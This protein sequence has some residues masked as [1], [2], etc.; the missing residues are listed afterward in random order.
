MSTEEVITL[1]GGLP[2]WPP[3]ALA[4]MVGLS[5]SCL[6]SLVQGFGGVG[7]LYTEMLA[8]KRL[9]SDTPRFSPM[10]VRSAGEKPLIYQLVAGCVEHIPA[11]VEKLH[12]LGADG[13]DLNLGCP[14]PIQKRQGAGSFL[15]LNHDKLI[16]IL[17]CLRGRTS[18]PLS[19]KIRLGLQLDNQKLAETCKFYEDQGIDCVTVHGRLH[20]EKFC[21]K[22]KWSAIAAAK[23][24]V[25]I[26]VFAN[27]GIFSVA[28]AKK[29]LEQSGA[30]GLMVGRAAVEKP[31][32]C[33][34]IAHHIY[35]TKSNV[36]EKTKKDVF[37]DFFYLLEE[38]F[39]AEK[40]LGRLKQ[41][42][43]YYA[44]SFKFG[45]QL[46]SCILRSESMVEARERSDYF[47][48]KTA[49]EELI[50]SGEV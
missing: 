2:I 6:R 29:C 30:D 11:A 17:Q 32:L 34:E 16:P 3:I 39:P 12:K 5:H 28:D 47:F 21:R 25:S 24:A 37:F 38:R 14:A 50:L 13:I 15:A 4:P 23:N 41:F 45:H 48:T 49:P 27:G 42:S 40:R 1:R 22:P 8:A 36:G 43:R 33:S 35:G 20:G 31:W 10:L 9:P 18:L 44:A 26:P 19:V 7:L 46:T